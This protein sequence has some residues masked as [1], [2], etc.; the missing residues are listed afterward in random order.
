MAGQLRALA[1]VSAAPVGVYHLR[2]LDGREVDVVLERPD[3]RLVAIE[4]K[5]RRSL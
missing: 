2:Q 4:V 5:A 3:R 1:G